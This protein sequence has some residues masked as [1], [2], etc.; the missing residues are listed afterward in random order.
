MASFGALHG[1]DWLALAGAF[2]IKKARAL[3]G[4]LGNHYAG[5]KDPGCKTD[6]INVLELWLILVGVRKWGQEWENKMVVFV[7][8]NMQGR[9]ALNSGRS[10]NK[11]TMKSLRLIF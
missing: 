2:D 3:E 5:A 4:W 10:H 9:E 11:T 8:D 1:A 6:N 7:T